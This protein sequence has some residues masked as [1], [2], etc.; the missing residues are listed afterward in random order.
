MIKTEI[1]IIGAGASGLAAAYELSLVNKKI[2]VLEARDRTGGRIHSI[3]DNSFTQ[4]AEAGAEFIHGKLPVTL[5]LL[6]KAGIKHHAV[7]GKMWRIEKG[8]INKSENFIVGWKKIMS[9]LREL[10]T[11]MPITQFLNQHFAGEKDK[12]LRES[13]LKFVEGYDAA[14]AEK[15]S[16]FALRDEWESEDDDNEERID[17]GYIE[18]INFLADEIKKKDNDIFLSRTVTSISWQ[19]RRR[20]F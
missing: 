15:A 5:N 4:I 8:E 14:D 7:K 17:K 12:A 10:K 6:K 20:R 13:V 11:D 9:S 1:L 3:N 19:K 16:S 2:I 18:L